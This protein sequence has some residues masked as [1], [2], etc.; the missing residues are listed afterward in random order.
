MVNANLLNDEKGSLDTANYRT[1]FQ[2]VAPGVGDGRANVFPNLNQE[3][4][5]WKN[6]GYSPA[7]ARQ[8]FEN[9]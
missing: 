4:D 8:Y 6:R 1:S 7:Q 3:I 9:G 2:K 5:E